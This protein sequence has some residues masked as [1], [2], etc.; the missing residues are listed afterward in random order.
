MEFYMEFARQH[1]MA[2]KYY[3]GFGVGG[4]EEM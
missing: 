1:G 4:V 3:L 2:S